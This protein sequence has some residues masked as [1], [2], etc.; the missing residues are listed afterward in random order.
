M[1]DKEIE[2]L[3]YSTKEIAKM[4]EI[5]STTTINYWCEIFELP[6][7]KSATPKQHRLLLTEFNLEQIRVIKKLLYVDMYTLKGAKRQFDKI[8]NRTLVS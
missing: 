2:R 3:Y 1:S 8:Y 6:V 5:Q 7:E 4:L